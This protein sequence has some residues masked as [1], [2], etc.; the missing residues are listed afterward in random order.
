MIDQE[1]NYDRE[2]VNFCELSDE[3]QKEAL[4]N[5]GDRA[6]EITYIKPLENTNSRVNV[7]FDLDECMRTDKESEFDGI[8]GISNTMA[9][10]VNISDCGDMCKLTVI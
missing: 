8:I 2:L 1:I 4:S 5:N 9:F 7:L 10:G 3:W 6:E